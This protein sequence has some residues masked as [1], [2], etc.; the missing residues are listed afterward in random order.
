MSE[1]DQEQL[2][3]RN[4]RSLYVIGAI[5]ALAALAGTFADIV[6]TS[7]PGWEASTVPASIGQWFAQFHDKPLLGLRNLDL[8]NVCVSVVGLPMYL[9]LYG[10]H[11]KTSQ[12]W[13]VSAL[14]VLATGTTVFVANNAALPMLDLSSQYAA[15]TT[16][17]ERVALEGAGQALLA[18]G[19]HGSMG[20]FAG[21]FLSSM[22]ALLMALA[23]LS[24]RVFSRLAAYTGIVGISLLLLYVVGSTFGVG[25]E[26]ARMALAVPGGL[27]MIA[28]N[29]I[30]ARRLLQLR[31]A[32]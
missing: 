17:T 4:W 3:D 8:L 19:A 16:E 6:I 32:A 21:F 24:G 13:A 25:S 28:W 27:L 7:L 10:A 20:A 14:V 2:A 11:R 12:A 1:A 23:M 5:A 29:V 22:G 31:A 26:G 15:A 30:I 18:K 9:A